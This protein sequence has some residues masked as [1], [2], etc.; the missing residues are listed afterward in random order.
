MIEPNAKSNKPKNPRRII[1]WENVQGPRAI[2]AV[3]IGTALGAGLVPFA[4]GTAG[5][6]AAL[7]LAYF[8]NEWHWLARVILWLTLLVAGTW[9]A[10]VFDETMQTSDNQNVV[11]DEVV[12]LGITA[13][14]AGQNP[15]ALVTAFVLFRFFDI[16]KPWPVRLIDQWSKNKASEGTP[17]A[18]WYG[19]FG[20]MADDVAAGFQGLLCMLLLQYFHVLPM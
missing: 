11:M 10:K 5:S 14:T 15:A 19:G 12:G 4:P 7:P 6:L 2:S 13:W 1:R 16:V 18:Q 8:S 20:V 3:A 9:A 17:A